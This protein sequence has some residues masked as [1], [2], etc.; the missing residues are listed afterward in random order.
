[1]YIEDTNIQGYAESAT[2]DVALS[3]YDYTYSLLYKLFETKPT[4]LSNM[5]DLSTLKS[6]IKFIPVSDFAQYYSAIADN[7]NLESETK[8]TAIEVA[9]VR[10]EYN[11][12]GYS[13]QS[14]TILHVIKDLPP[15]QYKFCFLFDDYGPSDITLK[16]NPIPMLLG[17]RTF[18]HEEYANFHH[19]ID[20]VEFDNKPTEIQHVSLVLTD[21]DESVVNSPN[22]DDGRTIETKGHVIFHIDNISVNEN[23][24]F[25]D[26]NGNPIRFYL[27]KSYDENGNLIGNTNEYGIIADDDPYKLY[28]YHH[29]T[30]DVII[31]DGYTPIKIKVS[32]NPIWGKICY[33]D[34]GLEIYTDVDILGNTQISADLVKW[35]FDLSGST[36]GIGAEGGIK[37]PVPDNEI[38]D[39]HFEQAATYMYEDE[40]YTAMYINDGNYIELPNEYYKDNYDDKGF[41]S[42]CWTN[43]IFGNI[44]FSKL[45]YDESGVVRT[46]SNG[47][48]IDKWGEVLTENG[49]TFRTLFFK[50]YIGKTGS[51]VTLLKFVNGTNVLKLEID[52]MGSLLYIGEDTYDIKINEGKIQQRRWYTCLMVVQH[53]T[54]RY[55]NI[56]D[57]TTGSITTIPLNA[58]IGIIPGTEDYVEGQAF[59]KRK[60]ADRTSTFKASY[61]TIGLSDSS[62]GE[63]AIV[64]VVTAYQYSDNNNIV[65]APN[66]VYTGSPII[67]QNTDD[68]IDVSVT[69][70]HGGYS[71]IPGFKIINL[72]GG[73]TSRFTVLF[74]YVTIDD[75][76]VGLTTKEYTIDSGMSEIFSLPYAGTGTQEDAWCFDVN[77]TGG[78]LHNPIEGTWIE[79]DMDCKALVDNNLSKETFTTADNHIY[80]GDNESELNN[81]YIGKLGLHIAYLGHEIDITN[82][83]EFIPSSI[84]DYLVKGYMYSPK[85]VFDYGD[86]SIELDFTHFKE[87][88][89]NKVWVNLPADLPL[90]ECNVNIVSGGNTLYSTNY[91]VKS[92]K[93]DDDTIDFEIDFTKD[94]N[95]ALSTFATRFYVRQ[96][97]RAG[98]LS[99]GENGHLIYFNRGEQCAV[100]ENHGDFYEGEICCNEK[101]SGENRWYGG[102]AP[103][104]QFPLESNGSVKWYSN[105]NIPNPINPRTQRVGSLIQSKDYYGYGEFEIDMKIPVDFKG[106]AICWWMFHYQELYWPLDKERFGF[107]AG[108]L[109]DNGGLDEP[110]HEYTIG[111]KKGVWNYRH[112]F[113]TDSGLPYII[114]NNEIDMELGSEI[115]QINTTKN[116]NTDS[117]I[118]FYVPLLDP[119]TVIGCTTPGDNYGLWMLDYNAS[120]P[121]IQN[122]L[123][124]IDSIEGDYIDRKN[125][126]YLGITAAELTWVHVS[127]TI[128]DTICY[129]A[130]TRAI[131]WNNW[132]TEPDIGGTL[133]KTKYSNV[134]KAANGFLNWDDGESGWDMCN[135]VGSTT[136]RTPL[137]TIDLTNPHIDYR[138]IPHEMDDG[139][140]HTYKFV[141]HR[142]YTEC[143][144]D[145]NI[146]RRNSTCSPFI[147][148]PFLIGGWFP[149]DN[150]WG[151]YAKNGYF[152]TWA[153]VK[154]PWDI[155]HF[156]IRRIKY[157]HYTESQSSRDQMLYHGETYPYSG[158][159]AF[160]I[161]SSKVN[162][163]LNVIKQVETDDEVEFKTDNENITLNG[164]VAQSA[165]RNSGIISVLCTDFETKDVSVLFDKDKTVN[166]NLNTLG[167]I[168]FTVL[169]QEKIKVIIKINEEIIEGN[170]FHFNTPGTYT[171]EAYVEGDD[172]YESLSGSVKCEDITIYYRTL[173]FRKNC[174]VKFTTNFDE[175][176]LSTT[177]Q[178]AVLNG[179]TITCIT[180]TTLNYIISKEG[181]I[182]INKTVDIKDDATIFHYLYL[183]NT[184]AIVLNN[185]VYED[186]DFSDERDNATIFIPENGYSDDTILAKEKSF[187]GNLIRLIVRPNV[188]LGRAFIFVADYYPLAY[189][190]PA[191]TDESTDN[192]YVDLPLVR[193]GND[194]YSSTRSVHWSVEDGKVIPKFELDWGDGYVEIP[195]D[196]HYFPKFDD[197]IGIWKYR[198]SAKGYYTKEGEWLT[199][200][201]L[202]GAV[203]D[204]NV[205]LAIDPRIT[206]TFDVLPPTTEIQVFKQGETTYTN[207]IP[208]D[209][210]LTFPNTTYRIMM[211]VLG[212]VR[213]DETL[214]FTENTTITLDLSYG[215]DDNVYYNTFEDDLVRVYDKMTELQDEATANGHILVKWGFMTDSHDNGESAVSP[216]IDVTE[217][218]TDRNT[219]IYGACIGVGTEIILHGGDAC[220]Y[221][222]NN[223][224]GYTGDGTSVIALPSKDTEPELNE[225]TVQNIEESFHL[226]TDVFAE[227][228]IP[229]MYTTGN[230]DSRGGGVEYNVYIPPKRVYDVCVAPFANRLTH[231]DTTN[232]STHSYYD[233]PIMVSDCP[234]KG[235]RFISCDRYFD[236]NQEKWEGTDPNVSNYNLAAAVNTIPDGYRII[237]LSH[238]TLGPYY[239]GSSSG[240]QL[241]TI[242]DPNK[243]YGSYDK[244]EKGY[245][246]LKEN[247][248]NFDKILMF[249][250][251]HHHMNNQSFSN[252]NILFIESESA[253]IDTQDVF[254]NRKTNWDMRYGEVCAHSSNPEDTSYSAFDIFAFNPYTLKLNVIRL[255]HGGDREFDLANHV[256]NY[257]KCYAKFTSNTITDFSEY[258]LMISTNTDTWTTAMSESTY[259]HSITLKSTSTGDIS[260]ENANGETGVAD[261]KLS[262]I[263]IPVNTNFTIQ[264]VKKIGYKY[265]G[266]KKLGAY[267]WRENSDYIIDLGEIAI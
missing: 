133:Y 17:L 98:D 128:N 168:R 187:T 180:G 65:G 13:I 185:T 86:N 57:R 25:I 221:G 190:L 54:I 134:V 93:P 255:G 33:Q 49:Y 110:C 24:R 3:V 158:L 137:G 40:R 228:T 253:A 231:T 99:G 60:N 234:I 226:A 169:N 194:V 122:K 201:Y 94:F 240:D 111:N 144:I 251:G 203:N 72:K 211:S 149:S 257:G 58:G 157:T 76:D 138:Y 219:E 191:I 12:N 141:W 95:N 262:R 132:W 173:Y 31:K 124:Q 18:Y 175:F 66:T 45:S 239:Y 88:K 63:F 21:G 171:Y 2:N 225:A 135:T 227:G 48:Y 212:E 112:S 200:D 161:M 236:S 56:N 246:Y 263:G 44:N 97:K 20:C 96:E 74:D 32:D 224:T 30:G 81:V 23:G 118:I 250:N 116:P 61:K 67:L 107:Y 233:V 69:F 64:P 216:H 183:E 87:L 90:G 154:A 197:T 79:L 153:G 6:N 42:N 46:N 243:N 109:D 241:K 131:R 223:Y 213:Y 84:M 92:V 82:P 27:D 260:T 19:Y 179:H 172:R 254:A 91:I 163:T 237:I 202:E 152:G 120:L 156:Y 105:K 115:N 232:Y 123:N 162:V 130:S 9:I 36:H 83:Y 229:V 136:P 176:E 89:N 217:G 199:G 238:D 151:D 50:F 256:M 104:I 143:Y 206:I 188:N 139:K 155:R 142:D 85:V 14:S 4:G 249:I 264:V 119:R 214:T 59:T 174:L 7:I 125:G 196:Y 126:A 178:S 210:F 242:T 51:V 150:S 38:K 148:M 244:Y 52:P 252:D 204:L 15:H 11:D 160:E 106:E 140:W 127:T 114:V 147:P 186:S 146:I 189:T 8:Y 230:H 129:D 73:S 16:D 101:D 43:D 209:S 165:R 55:I 29:E 26:S 235:I 47:E 167:V 208:G 39:Y 28:I 5:N 207:Y 121:A 267:I 113:K 205:V 103:Q 37:Y 177:T 77:S 195:N 80:L 220:G 102:V 78:I 245:K 266:V 117:S 181:Y 193:A 164:N 170:V 215:D 70:T 62:V 35:Y 222:S 166:V 10:N 159:R 68:F 259:K 258:Y 198:C 53:G 22:H 261:N 34:S 265:S 247:T 218:R 108:G 192:T 248:I 145:G 41:S 100:F 1:M 75:S 71:I 184:K 182:T